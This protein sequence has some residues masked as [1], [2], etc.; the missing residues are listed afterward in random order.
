MSLK[1]IY[2]ILIAA[3]PLIVSSCGDDDDNI[4]WADSGSNSTNG[5]A[6]TIVT[7][8]MECPR[9]K[10]DANE[11][12]IS[13]W[14]KRG[15]DSVM[16]YCLAYDLQKLH[17]RWVAFRFDGQTRS[18]S[19]S[20]SQ[21][22]FS[23]DPNLKT[24]YRIGAGTYGSGY[25]RGHICASADRLYSTTANDQ[26]FYMT[27]MS[28]QLH[29]FNGGYWV[30]LE[31]HVQKLGRNTAFSDT[32]YVVKGGT[33]NDIRG[34]LTR[35][36]GTT[37]VVPRYYFMALLKIKNGVYS[38][39]GFLMEHKNYPYNFDNKA[40]LSEMV[41]HTMTINDLENATGID[42]FYNLPD[43]LEEMVESQRSPYIWYVQ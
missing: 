15:K 8:R 34:T 29:D 7:R 33:V 23:D 13:H 27:N 20:R 43:D 31:G 30:T 4:L 3:L 11:K 39:I 10:G 25:D 5:K 32:L 2:F 19:V 14:T 9:L 18:K 24:P 35:S 12:L 41:Q 37:T 38:S 28:P 17:S 40:P 42:F 36:N 1:K 21:E 26:T 6:P 22:P 16:T